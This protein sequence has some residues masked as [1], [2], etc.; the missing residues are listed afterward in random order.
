MQEAYDASGDAS[1]I[2]DRAEHTIFEIAQSRVRRDFVPMREILKHS[3]EVIQELYDKK[4]HVT[5]I[6][7]GPRVEMA[8]I[9]EVPGEGMASK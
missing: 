9:A 6:P 3:F 7:S 1:E 8:K 2:L 5:G 4:Q